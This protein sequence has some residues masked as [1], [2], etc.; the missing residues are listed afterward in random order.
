MRAPIRLDF[1]ARASGSALL[2]RVLLV[3]GVA[4]AV[5]VALEYRALSLHRAGL[6]VRVAAQNRASRRDPVA[7]AL[8]LRDG[9][10]AEQTARELVTPWTELL[11]DLES[12]S[13]DT[14]GEVAL[15]GVE[16][17]HTKHRVHVTGESKNLAL[18]IAYVQRLQS[19]HTL[20][21]PMLDS[22]ELRADDPQHPVRFELTG[23]WQDNL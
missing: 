3:L 10:A 18:A 1:V 5:A 22:H 14:S 9:A 21:Y 11:A 23:E 12:A 4:A 16:P 19:V 7:D 6:E 13:K 17:D 20:R 8:L 15:L 2:A